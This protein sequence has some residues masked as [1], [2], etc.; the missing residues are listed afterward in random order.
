MDTYQ[1]SIFDPTSLHK[2]LYA[3]ANPVMYT[4]PSGYS[5]ENDLDFY[6]QAWLT[7]DQAADYETKLVC[8]MHNEV[9]YDFQVMQIGKEIIHNLKN[10]GLEYALTYVL[11]PY[12]GPN[13]ASTL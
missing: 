4:D 2:Y 1:G 10:T 8:N 5:V 13:V 6:Q 12:V 3:N 11:E 9:S 7:V